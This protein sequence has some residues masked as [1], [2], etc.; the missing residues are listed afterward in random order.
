MD[1]FGL[2]F[3]AIELTTTPSASLNHSLT[4]LSLQQLFTQKMARWESILERRSLEFEVALPEDLPAI[5]IRDPNMLD[6][7]LTGLIEQLSHTLPFGSQISLQI[8]LAGEQLKL[9][10][11]SVIPDHEEET[12]KSSKSMLKAVGQLLMLQPE[13]GNLSLSLPATKEI[14]NF[15]GG[16]LTVRQSPPR[17]EVLTMFLP[18]DPL[19]SSLM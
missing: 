13:T 4:T 12:A 9:Q 7:V 11:R 17:G 10:L 3:R 19:T 15:L 6:Q 5:A 2:I 1:R 8:T 14:F 16:K 18:L